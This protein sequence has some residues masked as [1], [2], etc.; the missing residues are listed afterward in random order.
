MR[1]LYAN[2]YFRPHIGGGAEIILEQMAEGMRERGHEVHVL[3]TGDSTSQENVNGVT[4]HRVKNENIYWGFPKVRHSAVARLLWHGIDRHNVFL[5]RRFRALLSELQPDVV[6][7]HNLSGLSIALWAEAK[8]L[9]IPIMH[10]LH[11]FYLLCPGVTMFKNGKNCRLPCRIC[12]L[13]RTPHAEASSAVTSV[14]GVSR[15]VLDTHLKF[16]YFRDTKIKRVIY[17]AQ[18]LPVPNRSNELQR[19]TFERFGFIGSLSEIKG[20]EELI[21][22]FIMAQRRNPKISLQIAGT[23]E[24]SFVAHLK[25]ISQSASIKFI[26]HTNSIKFYQNIDV[27]VAPSQSNDS[28]PGVVYESISQGVPVI[29]AR[30]GGIPEIIRDGINGRLYDP[31]EKDALERLICGASGDSSILRKDVVEC[32]NSVQH[33]T[34]PSRM[35][36]EHEHCMLD[37][38]DQFRK[39]PGYSHST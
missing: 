13:L 36:D 32:V 31:H 26:G 15:A 3:A 25:S 17:N 37:T 33:L 14:I 2:S 23:G 4:V 19:A 27:C 22:S 1:I 6:A 21:R 28:F 9:G 39:Q 24:A 16:G 7:S 8:K 11:D 35:L 30:N 29:G 20:V 34:R 18:S 12:K 5:A 38:I 10:V